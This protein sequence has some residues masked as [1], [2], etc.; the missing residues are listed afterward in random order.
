MDRKTT[1]QTQPGAAGKETA[2]SAAPLDY[3][4]PGPFDPEE[5]NGQA[6]LTVRDLRTWF[7]V[8]RGVFSRVQ[9]HVKAVDGVSFSVR[10]GKTLGLVGENCRAEKSGSLLAIGLLRQRLHSTHLER[11]LREVWISGR[12]R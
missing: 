9:A 5:R 3:H 6:I 10:R 8:R 12:A 2:G 11:Q 1:H 7:P 4:S